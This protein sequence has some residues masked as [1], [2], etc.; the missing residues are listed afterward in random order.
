MVR[1]GGGLGDGT[2]RVIVFRCPCFVVVSH[3]EGRSRASWFATARPISMP[4]YR[5]RAVLG[6]VISRLSGFF[7]LAERRM[8]GWR[9]FLPLDPQGLR[10]YL[11]DAFA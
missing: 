9:H 3:S 8:P 5:H 2:G 11:N 10:V 6:S 4:S 1:Q 7:A